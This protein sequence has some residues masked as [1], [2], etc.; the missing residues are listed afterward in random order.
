MLW[1]WNVEN[2]SVDCVHVCKG[3]ERGID[4]VDISPD[5]Q[6]FATGSW[7]TM[8]KIWSAGMWIIIIFWHIFV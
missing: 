8:L 6:R 5:K 3:H 1:E 2:N 4:C 7:D